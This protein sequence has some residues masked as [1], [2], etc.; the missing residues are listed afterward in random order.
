MAENKTAFKEFSIQ[1][2]KSEL[3]QIDIRKGIVSFEY[4]EDILSPT[5]TARVV[6]STV[7]IL[8][9]S[10]KVYEDDM[11]IYGGEGVVFD[12][13][14]P[15]FPNLDFTKEGMVVRKISADKTGRQGLYVLELVS[16]EVITNETVRVVRRYETPIQNSVE[17]I[18]KL[19]KTTKEIKTD[20]TF[21]KYVF[22]GNTRR[23]FDVITWLCPKSVPADNGTPGF[24]FYENQEGYKFLS[25]NNLLEGGGGKYNNIFRQ[26]EKSENPGDKTNNFRI[27]SSNITKNNDIV[28]SLRMGMYNNASIFYQMWENKYLPVTFN[29]KTDSQHGFPG[30]LKTSA[31]KNGKDDAPILPDGLEDYASRY[32]V[33]TLDSGALTKAGK[34]EDLPHLPK[35]QAIAAVRYSLLYSQV[36]NIHIPCNSELRAGQLIECEIPKPTSDEKKKYESTSTG[37]YVIASLCHKINEAGQGYTSLALIKDSYEFETK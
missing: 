37:K 35:Y 2:L 25:A 13:E 29:L 11:P 4:F 22:I 16:K 21:N 5:I 17:E 18:L 3:K 27:L 36:L 30:N 28:M 12:I 31:G 26:R 32:L 24:F 9:K 34:L 6:F 7:D 33:R 1:P 23:P 10:N 14:V 19:L 15:D 8:D 20:P